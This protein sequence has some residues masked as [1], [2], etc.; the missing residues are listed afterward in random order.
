M[1]ILQPIILGALQGLSEF[2]PISSSAHLILTP[3]LFGWADQ[4]LAFDVALHWG[5]LF[6]VVAYFYKDIWSMAKGF[7]NSLMPSRRDF[8][9]NP[10]QKLAWLVFT[11]TIPAALL[12]KLFEDQ[13]STALRN[14]LLIAFT[15]AIMGILLY[16]GDKYGP[17]IKNVLEVVLP[18]A[19]IIGLAQALAIIPGFSRSGST[20]TA[21]L[22]LGFTRK[23]AAKF[24][25][26]MSVPIIL[27]AGLL[28]IPEIMSLSQTGSLFLGFASSAVFGFLAIKYMLRYIS[29]RSFAIFTWYRLLLAGLI[30]I[31]YLIRN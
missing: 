13:V 6:A 15:S 9:H 19:V 3:W 30:V 7:V 24:S 29:S 1:E 20:I 22:F 12:G 26:L 11:A 17:K 10:Y 5:T 21:G 2:L 31:I 16:V 4:G 18:D 23:D 27:G 25:F 8:H 14:P 28:K